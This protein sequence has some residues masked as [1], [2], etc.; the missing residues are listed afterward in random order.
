MQETATRASSPPG[1]RSRVIARLALANIGVAV[2]VTAL[3]YLAFLRT[4]SVALYSD[5]LESIVNVVTAVATLLAVRISRQPADRQHPFGHHKAEYFAAGLE[6]A[7]ILCAAVVILYE[8]YAAFLLPRSLT[9]PFAGLAINALAAGINGVW[10]WVVLR[11]GRQWRSPALI[12]DA[13]HV[14]TDVA[15]SLAVLAGLLLALA[16]GWA[17]LDPLMAALVAVNVLWAGWRIVKQ[18]VGGLMD[19]AVTAEIL[20][21]IRGV[22]ASSARGAI[23]VHDL[24]TRTAGPATFI[25]FHLVV[26]GA[27]PVSEAHDI[28]DRI[29]AALAEAIDG[30]EVLNSRRARGRGQSRIVTGGRRSC[31]EDGPLATATKIRQQ[32]TECREVRSGAWS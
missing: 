30:A 12:A 23:E 1:E 9:S 32:A 20:Q 5:A 22:I 13:W 25:E 14:L 17:V 31:C 4:D 10:A 16:T 26:P 29:E 6:G 28:C 7:L 19:E 15:T 27:M 8:A 3:K 18:S 24:R 2:A 21:R 11:A